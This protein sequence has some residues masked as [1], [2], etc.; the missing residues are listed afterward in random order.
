MKKIILIALLFA[1]GFYASF[2][3]NKTSYSVGGVYNTMLFKSMCFSWINNAWE[4]ATEKQ[5]LINYEFFKWMH[6]TYGMTLDI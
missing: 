6:D 2:A 4:G 5:T 1:G 3:Q